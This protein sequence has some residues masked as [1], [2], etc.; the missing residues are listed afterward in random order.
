[1]GFTRT[2][3]YLSL[4]ACLLATA[5]A[6]DP[7]EAP[8]PK[9]EAA[10]TVTVTAEASPVDLIKTP[11]PVRILDKAAIEAS[12]ART[13][14]DLLEDLFPGQILSNGG[15]G[16]ASSLFLGG[17]RNQDVVV[18]LDGVRITD[19]AGL[20]GVNANALG[21]AGIDRV[22]VQMGPCSSRF[23]SDAMGGAVA[24]Y[25]AG[26][27]PAGFTGT[28]KL[29][30]GTQGI[31]QGGLATAYGWTGGWVRAG[32]QA[33]QEDQPTPTPNPFRAT[34]AFLGLGQTLGEDSLLTFSYRNTAS[35]VPIPYESVKPRVYNATRED[36]SRNEQI[37]AT[38][39]TQFAPAWLGELTLGQ[40]L[41]VRQEPNWGAPGYTDYRSRRNQALGHVAWTPSPTVGLNA[42]VDAY[43]EF[44]A[45]P[46]YPG[47]TDRGQ[48]DHLALDLE[49][50]WEPLAWLRLVGSVRQQWDSQ[51]FLAPASPSAALA[52]TND[53]QTTWKLGVNA[54]LGAGCR[55]YASGGTGFSL[56][57]LSAVM[58]NG[59]LGAYG[60][61][62]P[63]QHEK[64]G[65]A[66]VGAGWEQGPWSAKLEASRTQFSHLVYF[67]LN[68]YQYA[69]GSEM[70]LQ[71]VE[72]NV[73]YKTAAW[74]AEGFWR[75][76]EAR[77]LDAPAGQQLSAGAVI[78]RPFNLFGLKGWRVM[79]ATRLEARW[80]YSG[81]RYE[82]FGD[83]LGAAKT[84]FNDLALGAT[85]SASPHLALSLRAE[86][87]LQP[88]TSVGEW[89]AGSRDGQND[90]AQIYGFPA[91]PPTVTLEL[92]YRF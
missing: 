3:F 52:D 29:A 88:R 32:L 63:L 18:T 25:T 66:R 74:G 16:S 68:S 76:Q 65:F 23:G 12:G 6:G 24:L 8:R 86:H 43:R 56:P 69:N 11:N 47:G 19:A 75:N 71:G 81:P 46:A 13:L 57:M 9:A 40:A 82:N 33:S 20:G 84:H 80:S 38:L 85:W 54:L 14:G 58:Y 50:N 45:T 77:K 90:A 28:A 89:L 1:M 35:G 79:G 15:V 87:L 61:G 26:S 91:Q 42:S 39:R 5:P 83:H 70:R 67:D 60:S 36:R 31:R 53:R 64:S 37:L 41:Q 59:T 17:A 51:K 7:G 78:R 62:I 21:L 44:A 30:F 72:G 4:G 2:T 49:A 92:R 55:L 34:G 22:E 27:A 10:A 48:G 73:A